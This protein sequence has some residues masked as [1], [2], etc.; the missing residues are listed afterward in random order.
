MILASCTVRVL[1]V[2]PTAKPAD[3]GYGQDYL[4]FPVITSSDAE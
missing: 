2:L 3:S 1:Y 4:F